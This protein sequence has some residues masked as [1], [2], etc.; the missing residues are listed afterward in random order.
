M[1]IKVFLDINILIDFLDVNREEHQN[2]SRIFSFVISKDLLPFTSESALCT[3]LY[4][5]RKNYSTVTVKDVAKNLLTYLKIIPCNNKLFI[6]SLLMNFDDV[7]DAL[8][9]QLALTENVN[10]FI[11]ND[12]QAQ[13]KLA[14][15]KL[16]VVS[17][18][19]FLKLYK[20]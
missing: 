18:K 11:T 7:E 1:V 17:S 10:Y 9:Y 3:T 13:M 6:E 15:K 16:P 2:A 20:K 4:L 8:L 14:T 12:K 19:Q 5:I